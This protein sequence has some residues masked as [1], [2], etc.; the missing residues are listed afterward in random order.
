LEW[1]EVCRFSKIKVGIIK[2]EFRG[3]AR[4][5]DRHRAKQRFPIKMIATRIQFI[6]GVYR[7]KPTPT[8]SARQSGITDG[9]RD[10]AADVRQR[11]G[12]RVGWGVDFDDGSPGGLIKVRPVYFLHELGDG[13]FVVGAV[14]RR[15]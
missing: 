3:G 4:I 11:P 14:P 8:A 15:I 1:Q 10:P 5:T 7:A 13:Q 2:L 6:F 9:Q 12:G